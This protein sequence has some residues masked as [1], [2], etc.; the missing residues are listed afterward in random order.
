MIPVT[1]RGEVANDATLLGRD[2]TLVPGKVSYLTPDEIAECGRIG[3][4]LIVHEPPQSQTQAAP[5]AEPAVEIKR[6][7][8]R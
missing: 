2:I 4:K 1:Y 8:R 3:I 6:R 7:K 5:T